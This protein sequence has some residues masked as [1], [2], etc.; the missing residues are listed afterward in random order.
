MYKMHIIKLILITYLMSIATQPL[1][2]SE[3]LRSKIEKAVSISLATESFKIKPLHVN[4]NL[5]AGTTMDLHNHLFEVM[6]ED[7]LL[8]HIYVGQAPSMKDVFDYVVILS[9]DFEIINTKVLIY[10]EQHGRQI[11]SKRWLKQFTGMTTAHRPKLG[12]EID[13]ISGAT[14]SANSMT[15]AIHDLLK[16]LDYLKSMA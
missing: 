11:G 2:W 9:P 14:I 3:K 12:N 1:P 15:I 8:A 10:R 13:G 7:K 5:E 16:D 4:N 6:A